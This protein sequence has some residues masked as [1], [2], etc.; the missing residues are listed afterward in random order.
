MHH[1][2]SDISAYTHCCQG[3]CGLES[4]HWSWTVKWIRASLLGVFDLARESD[5]RLVKC[6]E[7][8]A[9]SCL[10]NLWDDVGPRPPRGTTRLPREAAAMVSLVTVGLK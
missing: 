7:K 10:R 4:L 5:G 1:R 2:A 6:T 8:F 3:A 9:P